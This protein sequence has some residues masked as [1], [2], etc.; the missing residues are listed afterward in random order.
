[1]TQP[2]R[3]GDWVVYR[4]TK[5]SPAPGP[6]ARQVTA[7]PKGDNYGYVVDKYW[8][9]QDVSPEGTV[10]LL[11]RRGKQH[12]LASDDP[13]LRKAGPWVRF[14]QRERYQQIERQHGSTQSSL[15]G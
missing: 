15:S 3:P 11:T 5:R 7:S 8:V 2:F 12:E 9:V 10:R 6:R 4:K 14:W 13:A 1:M